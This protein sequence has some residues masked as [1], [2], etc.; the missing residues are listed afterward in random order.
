M[1]I[2]TELIK[3]PMRPLTGR[4]DQT[5]AHSTPWVNEP[6]VAIIWALSAISFALSMAA[7]AS[8]FVS[9]EA[10]IVSIRKPNHS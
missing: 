4:L 3:W 9:A 1:A 8:A 5:R 10:T 7:V 2:C 6:V